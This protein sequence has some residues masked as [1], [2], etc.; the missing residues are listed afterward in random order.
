M[1]C[2]HKSV[3]SNRCLKCGEPFRRPTA[4]QCPFCPERVG[5]AVAASTPE[6]VALAHGGTPCTVFV[7]EPERF[8]REVR[9]ALEFSN[10]TPSPLVI[11]DA[12][13]LACPFCSKEVTASADV[14]V[15]T[16]ALPMCAEFERLE[17]DEF[18]RECR[19]FLFPEDFS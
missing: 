16:H 17:P 8:A 11:S 2:D 14:G 6:T 15:L 4:I 13:R 1:A 18:L 3:G 9:Q 5:V 12:L 10:A 7:R 19:R